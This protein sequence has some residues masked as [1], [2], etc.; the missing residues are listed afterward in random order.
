MR[1]SA[2]P[3][4]RR[5]LGLLSVAALVALVVGATVGAGNESEQAAEQT[6]RPAPERG[7]RAS[8]EPAD[9]LSLRR[10]V[11]QLTISSFPDPTAPGYVRRR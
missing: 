2:D 5:R 6:G 8:L 4:A 7:G 1:L 10:Q 3:A 9:R 11:G